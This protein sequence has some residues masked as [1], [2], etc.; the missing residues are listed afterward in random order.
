MKYNQSFIFI[1]YFIL[2]IYFIIII[3]YLFHLFIYFLFFLKK[4]SQLISYSPPTSFFC[5]FVNHIVFQFAGTFQSRGGGWSGGSR[6]GG[7]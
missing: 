1:L 3:I 2:F 4:L 7:V 6:G 5:T